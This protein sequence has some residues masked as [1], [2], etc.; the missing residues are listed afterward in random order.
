MDIADLLKKVHKCE[1]CKTLYPNKKFS[2][3]SHGN[4]NSKFILVSEAPGKDSLDKDKYWSGV[5]GKQLRSCVPKGYELEDLVYLTDIVKCWPKG[6]N[7]KNRTPLPN[8]VNNCAAFLE[9]EIDILKPKLILS[10]GNL[11]S[12]FLLN[13]DIQIT[14]M[15]AKMHQLNNDTET[16]TMIHP[17]RIDQFMNRTDY[18]KQLSIVFEHIIKTL[19]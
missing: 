13:R 15:H 2:M 5:S 14:K 7:G 8:E 11:A 12:S 6:K 9:Q 1:T 17:A 10:F 3:T 19:K 16:L 4:V 18:Q